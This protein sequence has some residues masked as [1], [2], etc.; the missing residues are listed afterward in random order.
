[1]TFLWQ[2]NSINYKGK[3]E[4]LTHVSLGHYDGPLDSGHI[5]SPYDNIEFNLD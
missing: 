5:M 1:M 2:P 4:I 3:N